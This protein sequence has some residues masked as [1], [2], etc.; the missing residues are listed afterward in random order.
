MNEEY[1]TPEE[2]SRLGRAVRSLII[3]ARLH[4]SC[5]TCEYFT[6]TTEECALAGARPPA[7]TIAMGCPKYFELIPF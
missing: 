1:L 5:L 6:E 2:N 4:R 3:N 7:R